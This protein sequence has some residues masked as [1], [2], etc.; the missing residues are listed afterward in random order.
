M[1][2]ALAKRTLEENCENGRR[3]KLLLEWQ[4]KIFADPNSTA[5]QHGKFGLESQHRTG[6]F[7][8]VKFKYLTNLCLGEDHDVNTAVG[9]A[10]RIVT[11]KGV[12]RNMHA[13]MTPKY[14]VR[15]DHFSSWPFCVE[16]HRQIWSARKCTKS[17]R[18]ILGKC[19]EESP[20]VF[21]ALMSL[22]PPEF[23][24]QYIAMRGRTS[25]AVD[26]TTE[27]R[28]IGSG[29][30]LKRRMIVIDFYLN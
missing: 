20:Q 8:G 30:N 18:R 27:K 22:A 16:V 10:D 23:T 7:R 12:P 5:S 4:N 21:D 6:L 24:T 29:V 2:F 11:L 17:T 28:A 26:L 25:L 13:L 19:S 1:Y 15:Y 3:R 9:D 14:F